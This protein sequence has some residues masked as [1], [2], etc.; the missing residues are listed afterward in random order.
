MRSQAIFGILTVLF[1]GLSHFAA[2]EEDINGGIST[3]KTIDLENDG[4]QSPNYVL[5]MLD[6]K[7]L[8]VSGAHAHLILRQLA[9]KVRAEF[10]GS[11]MP[12]GSYALAIAD[13]CSVGTQFMSK[14]RYKK[15]W[16]E[17]H[18]FQT[19]TTYVSTEKSMNG[20]ALH[21]GG[22]SATILDSKSI[23][24]FHVVK[25]KFERVDCKAIAAN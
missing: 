13:S 5:L 3:I 22:K 25:E 23:A 17:I 4:P 9:G 21:K 14:E 1:A 20:A 10:E 2:A 6:I 16:S 15:S 24:L 18:S 12:K 11:G 7:K 8:G 19:K